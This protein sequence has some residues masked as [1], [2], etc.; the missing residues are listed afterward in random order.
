MDRIRAFNER[1]A[2]WITAALSSMWAAYLFT[3]LALVSLPQALAGGIA[4]TVTWT[5]QTFIQLVALAVLGA[6][7]DKQ[8]RRWAATLRETHDAVL[9]QLEG[10]TELV[11]A[12]H[13][14]HDAVHSPEPS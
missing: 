3:G 10:V 6:G 13:A 9:Q 11:A 12:L 8:T 14:K 7:Q 1:L 5:A 4:P 2:D